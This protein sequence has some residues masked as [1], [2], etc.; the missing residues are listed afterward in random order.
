[1]TQK[2]LFET[3]NHD[4]NQTFV[5]PSRATDK[6]TSHIAAA[7]VN[8][9]GNRKLFFET[10][11]AWANIPRTAYEVAARAIPIGGSM[12]VQSVFKSR[13]T[14]RKRAGELVK[15]GLIEECQP[16]ECKVNCNEATTYQVV[17]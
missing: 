11:E 17:K 6:Q 9:T 3:S 15:L 14:L 5:A 2:S 16:R 13:E 8:L 7:N 4:G 1:M 10:L 12:P